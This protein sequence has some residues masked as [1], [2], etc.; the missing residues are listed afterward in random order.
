MGGGTIGLIYRYSAT[1]LLSKSSGFVVKTIWG[2]SSWYCIIMSVFIFIII[3]ESKIVSKIGDKHK[4]ANILQ[5]ISSCSFGIY[6]L[7]QIVKYYFVSLLNI[8]TASI[9]FRTI[10]SIV[11]YFLCLLIVYTIKKIPLLK[12]IVP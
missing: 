8:N 1:Y 9:I 6:L 3:K 10:G 12:R 2:Y 4:V 7:H 5:I 11:I